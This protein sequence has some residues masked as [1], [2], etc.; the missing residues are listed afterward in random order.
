M[1]KEI[2][3]VHPLL[4]KHMIF[5]DMKEYTFERLDAEKKLDK[6]LE[7]VKRKYE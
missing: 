6:K 4:G 3:R 7:E 1:Y 2:L 5:M